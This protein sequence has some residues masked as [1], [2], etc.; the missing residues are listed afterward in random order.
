M[1]VWPDSGQA[2]LSWLQ[3]RLF[4]CPR[5]ICHYLGDGFDSASLIFLYKVQFDFEPT[6]SFKAGRNPKRSFLRRMRHTAR[7]Q[8]RAIAVRLRNRTVSLVCV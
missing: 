8:A 5:C 7:R 1:P 3:C 2:L 4:R 6:E